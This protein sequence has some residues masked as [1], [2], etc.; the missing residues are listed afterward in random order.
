MKRHENHYKKKIHSKLL[1]HGVTSKG[2]NQGF[3]SV[4]EYY[5]KIDVTTIMANVKE[6]TEATIAR[7]LSRLNLN[8]A[9]IIELHHYV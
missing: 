9:N 6:D 7:F 4:D 8:I 3:N 5:K 2:F 1:L